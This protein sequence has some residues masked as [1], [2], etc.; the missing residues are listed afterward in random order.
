MG[1]VLTLARRELAGYFFSPMAYIVGALF[2]LVC[3]VLF[4]W[5]LPWLDI[6]EV[7]S[8]GS[9]SSLRPLFE[10]LAY[11]MVFVGPLL[12]MRQIA[13]E[14]RSGT[15]ETLLTA[16]LTDAQV[17]LGKFTGVMGFYLALLAGTIPFLVLV[18]IFGQPDAGVAVMG[19]L[20]L[21]L[22][23]AA[24]VAVG[25]FTTTITRHQVVAAIVG[26]AILAGLSLMMQLL[27]KYAPE[28]WSYL[29]SL[30]NVMTYFQDFAKGVFD[31]R[32][33]VYFVSIAGLF[34]FLSIKTL[35]SK[36]WR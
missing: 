5:G 29:A 18:A 21:L 27:V 25:M 17:I 34:L 19:Y 14:F 26:I 10:N 23:G 31:T 13:E 2:L 32:A 11:I 7:F 28:P 36:R 16:P 9:E 15:V 3:G 22:L 12:T 35:E 6:R 1:K 33:L 4:F 24:F 8:S 30:L 20:G